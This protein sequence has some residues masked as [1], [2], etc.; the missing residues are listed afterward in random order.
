[1]Q[2]LFQKLLEHPDGWN[3]TQREAMIDLCLLGMYSDDLISLSEQ[4]FMENEATH[5]KWES[6]ISFSGYLQ[7][8]IP[9]IRSAKGD[10]QN[11]EDLLQSI[12]DRLGS[13]ELKRRA[14]SEMEKLIAVDGVVK[15]E[16]QF[17]SEVHR[18]MGI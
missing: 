18:V 15:L 8:T 7:R 13:D 5:L 6:A 3:Q 12:G 1:M 4:D 2:V 11:V 14:S 16:E 9:K 17:L 10:S